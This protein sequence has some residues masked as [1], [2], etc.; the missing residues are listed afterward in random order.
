MIIQENRLAEDSHEISF[1]IFVE[2]QEL[3]RKIC[4]LLQS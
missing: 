4:R 2:N 3:C 1:L